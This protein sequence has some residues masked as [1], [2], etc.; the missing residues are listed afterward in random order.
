M[1]IHA[2]QM[3]DPCL[4]DEDAHLLRAKSLAAAAITNPEQMANLMG[5]A[6]SRSA[7]TDKTGMRGADRNMFYR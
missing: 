7:E 2:S 1:G 3:K 5:L 6:V 4:A